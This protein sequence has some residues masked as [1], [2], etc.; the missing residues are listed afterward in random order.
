MKR[1]ESKLWSTVAYQAGIHPTRVAELN[2]ATS[3]ATALID[4]QLLNIHTTNFAKVRRISKSKQVTSDGRPKRDGTD[5][6]FAR[7]FGEGHPRP[8]KFQ[9]NEAGI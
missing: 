9:A 3:P 1:A 4:M 6:D 5:K 8:E 7:W 2:Y